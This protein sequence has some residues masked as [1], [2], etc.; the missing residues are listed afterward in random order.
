MR[1]D[2]VAGTGL[3]P[4]QVEALRYYH[5]SGPAVCLVDPG[6][7]AAYVRDVHRRLYALTEPSTNTHVGLDSQN[8][9]C[10][11]PDGTLTLI[12]DRDSYQVPCHLLSR[13]GVPPAT[14]DVL[15]DPLSTLT[16]AAH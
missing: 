10:L 13:R 1:R 14:M 16:E 9:F 8:A 7:L 11:T 3:T 5:V 12:L 4:V 15:T 2:H 6:F